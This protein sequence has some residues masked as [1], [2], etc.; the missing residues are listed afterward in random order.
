MK[1]S[2]LADASPKRTTTQLPQKVNTESMGEGVGSSDVESTGISTSVNLPFLI[3]YNAG[4]L[5]TLAAGAT[6]ATGGE[7]EKIVEVFRKDT[8]PRCQIANIEKIKNEC[9]E[10]KTKKDNYRLFVC[11]IDGKFCYAEFS[12]VE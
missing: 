11:R 9:G 3:G 6:L 5:G 2:V 7:P 4:F 10:I 1:S 12:E 8:L